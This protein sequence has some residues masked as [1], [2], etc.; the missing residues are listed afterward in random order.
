MHE[1][2]YE[3]YHQ[4]CFQ[5]GIQHL[6]VLREFAVAQETMILA[7]DNASTASRTS[8]SVFVN[9]DVRNDSV[10]NPA[11]MNLVVG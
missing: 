10:S 7:S 1:N 4:R 6:H 9:C 5:N 8:Y 3:Q 11:L 2:A